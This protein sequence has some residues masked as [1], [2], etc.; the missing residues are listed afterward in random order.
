M[1]NNKK[2]LERRA[3]V[4]YHHQALHYALPIYPVR[5]GDTFDER[6]VFKAGKGK[7]ITFA[8]GPRTCTNLFTKESHSDR[9]LD[10]YLGNIDVLSGNNCS[11]HTYKE[12]LHTSYV[13][14]ERAEPL[15][16]HGRLLRT[17]AL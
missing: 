6:G 16:L 17:S 1:E 3:D 11:C 10:H 15:S 4:E 2:E 12:T 8:D 7:I 9:L 13:T 14:G 5:Q